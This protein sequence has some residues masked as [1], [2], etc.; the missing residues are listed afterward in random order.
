MIV[1]DTNV[2]SYL[3][4]GDRRGEYYRERLRGQSVVISF[5]TWEEL[6][7]GA[8]ARGWG[9]RRRNE[10]IQ[11]LGNYEVIW[12]SLELAETC[13]RLRAERRAAGR[14]IQVA[15]AWIAATAVLLGCPLATEDHDFDGIPNLEIVR[16]P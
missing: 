12:P 14:Q 2:V 3:L 5:Q 11:H 10:L 15:D 6:W 9:S 8:Y 4:A 16:A 13:A 1:A 7:Y